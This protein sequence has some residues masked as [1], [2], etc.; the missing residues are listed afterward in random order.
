MQSGQKR[1]YLDPGVQ[2][3]D[4]IVAVEVVRF[5]ALQLP[6]EVPAADA[7]REEELCLHA[8]PFSKGPVRLIASRARAAGG[9]KH[10]REM[11]MSLARATSEIAVPGSMYPLASES[12][13]HR[14]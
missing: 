12:V 10:L 6:R 2:G 4:Q 7:P 14:S 9:F 1:M 8:A 5:K 13:P 3:N 11:S